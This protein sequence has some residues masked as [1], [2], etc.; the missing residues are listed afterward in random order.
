MGEIYVGGAG[1]AQGYLNRPELTA[2]RFLPVPHAA[3]PG[4]RMYR[5]GDLAR[6]LA[7][8]DLVF[9]GRADHQLK[10]RGVRV[11]PGEIE[12][13]LRECPGVRAALVA[14]RPGP[15]GETVLVAWLAGEP[16]VEPRRHLRARLPEVMVP[17]AYVFLESL[18][19]TA[20]GKVD[21][22][23]LP[24]PD[25]QRPELRG[26][27]TLPRTAVEIALASLWQDLLAVEEVGV[28]ESFFDLGGHSL[29]AGRLIVRVRDLFGVELPVRA[30]FESP[31][32]GA[33][34]V[35]VGRKLVEGADAELLRQV[36]AEI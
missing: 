32:V 23:A 15:R 17:A 7:G 19:V 34:A 21:R 13:V 8:G 31:T 1:V 16:A 9:L 33:M 27:R 28:E 25:W 29:M 36:L 10:I 30:V 24:D 12:A 35:A 18:P 5:T 3:G 22:A 26:E 14:P 11:E 20:H 4:A 6:S 2:E